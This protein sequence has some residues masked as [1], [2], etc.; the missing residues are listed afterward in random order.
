METTRLEAFS[1]GVFAIAITLLVISLLDIHDRLAHYWPE[2]AAF[3]FS[4]LTVGVMWVN[5]HHLMNQFERADRVFLFLN[6][7]LLMGIVFIP[8]PTALIGEHIRGGG[9]RGAAIAY[10]CTGIYLSI[11]FSALWHYGRT[12]VLRPDA[13]PKT[14]S[15]ITRSYLPGLPLY[16]TGTLIALGSP[17]GSAIFYGAIAVFYAVSNTFFGREPVEV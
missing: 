5:H 12:H 2:Y 1:D 13:D 7:L 17:V 16:L 6:L 8:F 11:F 15:G 9:A 14:V 4:F 3:A 10:G